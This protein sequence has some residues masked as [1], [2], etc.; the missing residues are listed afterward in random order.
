MSAININTD[1]DEGIPS[2]AVDALASVSAV[3]KMLSPLFSIAPTL[4]IDR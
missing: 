1:H 2:V 4:D 3:L